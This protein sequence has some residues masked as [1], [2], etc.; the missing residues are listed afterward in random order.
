LARKS[1]FPWI[2]VL[3]LIMI[4]PASALSFAAEGPENRFSLADCLQYAYHNSE[5][6]KSAAIAVTQSRQELRQA[7]AGLWPSLGYNIYRAHNE[8][9]GIEYNENYQAFSISQNLFTGG[10][11]S[12]GIKQARLQLA[13]AREDELQVKQQ[14]TCDVKQAYYQMWL[15]MQKLTVAQAAY[16]NM[17]KHF[18]NVEKKYQEGLVPRIELLQ[19]EVN[20]RK[21]KPDVIA[22]QNEIASCR[23]NL[24]L[25]IGK[26]DGREL[27]IE[28]DSWLQITPQPSTVTFTDALAIAYRER[29]E[30]RRMQNNIELAKAGVVIARAGY[31]PTLT[32][33]DTYE[34]NK[35][36]PSSYG[37]S[38]IWVLKLDLSGTLFN[39]FATQAKVAAAKAALQKQ[40]SNEQQLKNEIR[41]K[42]ERVFQSLEESIETIEVNRVTRDLAVESLRLTQIKRD[43]GLA[44]NTDLLDA[45]LDVDEAL[46]GYYKG[47]CKYLV[48]LANLDL[49]VGKKF[50][51]F[52]DGS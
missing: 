39:G 43:E 30:L 23:S 3:G 20:W 27:A 36:D 42:L 12:A 18:H 50:R 11:L 48:A 2:M 44:T 16:D 4:L 5:K 38:E 33:S 35:Y 28:G 8:Q 47:I 14:L 21:L 52:R 10:K 9:S 6:L 46:N 17:E 13:N 29:P 19:A 26:Q 15:A 1:R 31:Y 24:A 40:L 22:A 41:L 49:V 45:Q 34:N 51:K 32:L 37:S 7:M 25:L